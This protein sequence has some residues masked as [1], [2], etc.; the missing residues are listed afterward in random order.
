MVGKSHAQPRGEGILHA[1]FYIETTAFDIEQF[2]ELPRVEL[3][4]VDLGLL[5]VDRSFFKGGIDNADADSKA[6]SLLIIGAKGD[7]GFIEL[8]APLDLFRCIC[9]P[10]RNGRNIARGIS[11]GIGIQQVGFP[12]QVGCEG[13]CGI[14]VSRERTLGLCQENVEQ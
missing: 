13:S 1:E 9:A 3:K 12:C 7:I 2:L 4:R 14:Q 8:A 6:Q 10:F 5:A 11:I